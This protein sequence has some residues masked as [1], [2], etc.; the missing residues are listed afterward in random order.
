M[1]GETDEQRAIHQWLRELHESGDYE[2]HDDLEK[3][4]TDR[5]ND[6]YQEKRTLARYALA[7]GLSNSKATKLYDGARYVQWG[8]SKHYLLRGQRAAANGEVVELHLDDDPVAP[9]EPK[10]MVRSLGSFT[11]YRPLNPEAL[12]IRW[13]EEKAMGESPPGDED[14][15][16]PL[17]TDEVP[18]WELYAM[19]PGGSRLS[20]NDNKQGV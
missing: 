20:R 5:L 1:A 4:E 19:K 12:M 11:R 2:A 18:S 8:Y 3:Q 9:W 6:L 17:S 7:E 14:D 13:H 10:Q 15:D 16:L